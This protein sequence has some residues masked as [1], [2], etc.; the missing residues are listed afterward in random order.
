MEFL[1]NFS[2]NIFDDV[3][4][5]EAGINTVAGPKNIFDSL[6]SFAPMIIIMV[7]FYFFLILPQNRRKKRQEEMISSV[8]KGE[9]IVTNAGIFGKISRVDEKSD[10]VLVEISKGVEIKILKNQ[11]LNITSRNSASGYVTSKTTS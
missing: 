7:V 4:A 2:F 6:K 3:F 9:E 10:T 5:A 1:K 8:K 11:I